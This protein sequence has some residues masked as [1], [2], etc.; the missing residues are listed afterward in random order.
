M[1]AE[2][3]DDATLLTKISEAVAA[4]NEAEKTVA[5]AQAE[6]V[7]R[8]K[9]VGLLL[10]EA[11]RLHPAVR[12]FEA[13]L[14]RIDGL[15]LSRAYDLLRLA[16][17]RTTDDELKKDAR[18]RQR[19]SRASKKRLPRTPNIPLPKPKKPEPEPDS[20]TVT[21]TPKAN[22][23][24]RKAEAAMSARALAE[25]TF[26]CRTWLPKITVEAD[27]QK[28]RLL[29]AGLTGKPRAEAA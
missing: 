9:A 26:A 12:D 3:A 4:A 25:F 16:G 19:K 22:A 13:F 10:L 1:R 29:V 8:S 24:G 14:R 28:A 11:K 20:V 15:K 7:S 18:D 5:T 21:E 17:G 23:E 6:F 2:N 27:R